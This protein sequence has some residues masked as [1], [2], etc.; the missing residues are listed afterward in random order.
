MTGRSERIAALRRLL[1]A[2]I[3]LL[4]GAMGTMIQRAQPDEADYRGERFSSWPRDLKGAN[5]LLTLTKPELI[6]SIHRGYLDAGADVI[7][8]NTFN[9]NAPSLGDYGLQG[10]VYEI[11]FEAAR[12]LS[13]EDVAAGDVTHCG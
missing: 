2:R 1:E 9:A 11:N 8:T 13:N 5:D 6:A 3:V 12:L 10:L 7:E 4:D